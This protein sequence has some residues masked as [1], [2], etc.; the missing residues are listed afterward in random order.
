M[1]A[2]AQRC[3]EASTLLWK[4][5]THHCTSDRA[6]GVKLSSPTKLCFAIIVRAVF[7]GYASHE[8]LCAKPTNG[9]I[10]YFYGVLCSLE[11]LGQAVEEGGGA[12]SG[13]LP[14]LPERGR[15]R[16]LCKRCAH[17]LV[18]SMSWASGLATCRA[19]SFALSR[20][21]KDTIA[22]AIGV[23]ALASALSPHTL[24]C[25][26]APRDHKA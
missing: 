17:P 25:F 1:N 7:N 3:P 4:H 16:P 13:C 9:W 12:P 6:L 22:A 21:F 23:G 15:W 19:R 10:G 20:G 14:H 5:I 24:Y 18:A 11:P 26:I 8:G 2:I